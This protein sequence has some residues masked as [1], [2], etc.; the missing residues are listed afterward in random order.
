MKFLNILLLV[1]IGS[2]SSIGANKVNLTPTKNVT[3]GNLPFR[4]VNLNS[5]MLKNNQVKVRLSQD[6]VREN[7]RKTLG[8]D[9]V[10]TNGNF[11]E[12]LMAKG[13]KTGW[14]YL[15]DVDRIVNLSK[16]KPG[17]PKSESGVSKRQTVCSY[18]TAYYP[19]DPL[20][21]WSSWTP[22]SICMDN[23]YDGAPASISETISYTWTMTENFS[24]DWAE[25]ADVFTATF[26][27]SFAE[28]YG[29]TQS[30]TCGIPAYN[31][32]QAWTQHMLGAADLYGENCWSCPYGGGCDS[33]TY[34]YLGSATLPYNRGYASDTAIGCSAQ[35]GYVCV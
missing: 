19:V 29:F 6:E 34:S 8:P 11:S 27:I 1:G 5:T 16:V 31:N 20:Y 18:Y 26:G 23:S 21:G 10:T 33:S 30:W 15:E 22:C 2:V 28:S 17:E 35:P 32:G 25:I 7:I 3:V 4:S 12:Y 14:V 13:Y 9:R 24:G